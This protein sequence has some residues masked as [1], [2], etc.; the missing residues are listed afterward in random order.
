MVIIIDDGSSDGSKKW[1]RNN[2]PCV[3]VLEGSGN[4]WWSGAMNLGLDYVLSQTKAKYILLWNND[5]KPSKDYFDKI[6]DS[7]DFAQKKIICFPI[8]AANKS[9]HL[10]YFI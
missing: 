3:E 1:L 2:Y 6:F 5:I 4:L 10:Q 8:R 9:N 7:M